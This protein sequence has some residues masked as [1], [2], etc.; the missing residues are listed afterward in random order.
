M[1]R[2]HYLTQP[3]MARFVRFYPLEW[4]EQIGMRAGLFGCPHVDR[5]CLPG[6]FRVNDNAN[7]SMCFLDLT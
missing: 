4:N 5:Q 3:F 6:Y 7:C 2:T 1:E